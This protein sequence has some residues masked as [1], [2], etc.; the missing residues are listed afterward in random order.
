MLV[1]QV[2]TLRGEGT[3][4]AM[5]WGGHGGRNNA[6]VAI[7]HISGVNVPHAVSPTRCMSLAPCLAAAYTQR[8]VRTGALYESTSNTATA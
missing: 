8:A 7:L 2:R 5:G 4:G 1:S 6:C 3:A